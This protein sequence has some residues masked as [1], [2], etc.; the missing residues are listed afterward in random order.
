MKGFL[1]FDRNWKSIF[2][3]L[4]P[5]PPPLFPLSVNFLCSL[6][7]RSKVF[8]QKKNKL[9]C[10][11][12]HENKVLKKIFQIKFF[13]YQFFFFDLWN[14]K[15]FYKI[16]NKQNFILFQFLPILAGALKIERNNIWKLIKK[17][18]LKESFLPF[19]NRRNFQRISFI[20]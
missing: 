13:I 8:G 9:H 6:F 20:F 7:L 2:P 18:K 19:W 12:L 15:L 3:V 16:W 14:V 1:G 11:S 17:K 10:C 5:S 4:F